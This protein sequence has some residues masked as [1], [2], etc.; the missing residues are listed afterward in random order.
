MLE[1]F[2]LKT[3]ASVLTPTTSLLIASFNKV[4]YMPVSLLITLPSPLEA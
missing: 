3:L 2:V 1:E 4:P